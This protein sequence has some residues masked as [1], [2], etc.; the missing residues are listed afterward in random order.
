MIKKIALVVLIF[1]TA[2]LAQGQKKDSLAVGDTLFAKALQTVYEKYSTVAVSGKYTHGLTDEQ[3]SQQLQALI[4]I[5]NE[6]I[7]EWNDKKKKKQ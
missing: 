4:R 2:L 3:I 1:L 7:I 5:L 6:T